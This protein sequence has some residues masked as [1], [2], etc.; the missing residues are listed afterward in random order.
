MR[1]PAVRVVD[2]SK[3]LALGPKLRRSNLREALQG[4]F[5]RGRRASVSDHIWA[6][7][8]VDLEVAQGEVVGIIGRNGAGKSTLLR[9]LSRISAPT[10]GVASGTISA[11]ATTTVIGKMIRS[12]RLTSRSWSILSARSDSV[13]SAR[14]IGGWMIGTRAMYE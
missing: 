7:R 10:S 9:I 2:L 5:R 12:T 3:R 8:N 1:E 14:M 13:V 6:L 11:Q 4:V